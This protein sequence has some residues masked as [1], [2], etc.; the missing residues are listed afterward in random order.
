MFSDPK[1]LLLN[2]LK[3]YNGPLTLYFDSQNNKYFWSENV[4][5]IVTNNPGRTSVMFSLIA[6]LILRLVM[7]QEDCRTNSKPRYRRNMF[8]PFAFNHK[9]ISGKLQITVCKKLGVVY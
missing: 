6:I 8:G 3:S 4:F 1:C 2:E 7:V 5:Y 9:S